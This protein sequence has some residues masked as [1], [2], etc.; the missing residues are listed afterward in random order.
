MS[1]G[2]LGE[3]I[4]IFEYFNM[5]TLGYI[6]LIAIFVYV[7]LIIFIKSL[8]MSLYK[9][10]KDIKILKSMIRIDFLQLPVIS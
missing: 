10:E 8:I 9:K 3:L 7:V 1:L 5:F 4:P 2:D 6:P